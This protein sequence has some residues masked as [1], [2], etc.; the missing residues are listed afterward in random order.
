[1]RE[2][3]G[4]PDPRDEHHLVRRDPEL[5][6]EPLHGREDRVVAASRT[7]PDLL[8]R[9]EVL[10]REPVRRLR[11]GTHRGLPVARPPVALAHASSFSMASASSS[12]KIGCPCTFVNDTASTRNRPRTS[13]A[14]CPV[15]SSGIITFR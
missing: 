12:A 1:V 3:P 15:F 7:P 6:Q 9:G 14:S 4:T 2:P 11:P 13:S 8:V 5:R 10:L